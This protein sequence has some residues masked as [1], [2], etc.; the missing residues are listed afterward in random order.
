MIDN[1]NDILQAADIVATVQE[2]APDVKLE[3]KGTNYVGLCPFH[4]EKTGS[5]TVSPSKGIYKCF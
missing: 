5:F 1:A 2:F 3:K 4:N